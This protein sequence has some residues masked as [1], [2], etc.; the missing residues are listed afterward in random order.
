VCVPDVDGGTMI[1]AVKEPLEV[2]LTT[3]GEV[4]KAEPSKV[5]ARLAE[6]AKP[7]PET[8]AEEPTVPLA[9]LT[10]TVGEV[11]AKVREA[12]FPAESVPTN[13]LLP[14]GDELGMV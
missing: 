6:G 9:G 12:V 1:V 14:D 8:V 11:T 7:E 2:V 13:E 10:P 5:N 4:G 3:P